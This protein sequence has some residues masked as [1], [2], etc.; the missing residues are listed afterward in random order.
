MTWRRCAT[1]A[2]TLVMALTVAACGDDDTTSPVTVPDDGSST[3]TPTTSTTTPPEPAE[4]P[5]A[6][7]RQAIEQAY[8]D[9]WDAFI[10]ILSDPDPANPLIDQ[11]F[12]GASKD[13]LLDTISMD[14]AEGVVTRPPEDP[15]DF[16]PGIESLELVDSTT[17]TV[18]ECTIDGLVVERRDTGEVVNDRVSIV[19]LQNR[20]EL[21]DG[22]W[23]VSSTKL[24]ERLEGSDTCANES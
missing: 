13:A 1:L 18:I 24:I 23:K 3:T 7:T 15:S 14:I 19:R 10:E 17:A 6:E 16:Q 8:F 5:D 2:A 11:H 12:A 9:Q 21:I 20:F 4:D 22:R